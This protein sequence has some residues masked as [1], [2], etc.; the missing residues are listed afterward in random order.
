MILSIRCL[1]VCIVLLFSAYAQTAYSKDGAV[2]KIECGILNVGQKK[3]FKIP[4]ENTEDFEMVIEKVSVCCGNP[5]PT[6]NMTTIQPG[7]AAELVQEVKRTKP[8]PFS[9]NVRA[10]LKEPEK[11]KLTFV[12]VGEARQPIQA[13]V[14]WVETP[15]SRIDY[16]KK[17]VRLHRIHHSGKD[18]ILQLL[19]KRDNFDLRDSLVRVESKYFT[20]DLSSLHY[21]E[22]E[23][24][25][26]SFQFDKKQPCL[27]N[28]G[29]ITGTN[30]GHIVCRK[31]DLGD[32]VAPSTTYILKLRLRVNSTLPIGEL[33][34]RIVIVFKDGSECYIPLAFR[35]VGDIYGECSSIGV[36]RIPISETINKNFRI[37][38]TNGNEPWNEIKWK[39]EGK[40]SEAISVSMN[41]N[42]PL[43]NTLNLTIGIDGSCLSRSVKGFLSSYIQLLGDSE[44]GEVVSLLVY[45][46]R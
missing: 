30:S 12:I 44:G 17:E 14:G 15:L 25:T 33:S 37:H 41:D 45:G 19:A 22:F 16:S 36:G 5:K 35:S 1:L 7:N 29:T 10:F 40:L 27:T 38:F 31:V 32:G 3:E 39:T 42:N 20:L 28:S 26:F 24:G 34:D 46:Y 4:I 18:L 6:I 13:F 43:K 11:K 21:R 8:G 2:V 23:N 9:T